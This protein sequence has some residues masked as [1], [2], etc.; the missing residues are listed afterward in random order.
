ME[1]VLDELV[2]H[3]N[4]IIKLLAPSMDDYLYVFDL[5]NGCYYISENAVKRFK[6]PSNAVENAFVNLRQ[7][8]DPEDWDMLIE[9]FDHIKSDRSYNFHNLQY[10]WLG[11]DDKP[12]WINCRGRVLRDDD[13]NAEVVIGCIN[14]IGLRQKA[15]NISGL[16]SE[17]SFEND[18]RKSGIQSADFALRLGIDCFKEINENG[19]VEYRDM[20]LAETAECIQKAILKDQRLYKLNADEFLVADFSGRSVDTAMEIYDRVRERINFFISN[21]QYE[22]FY[23]ISGGIISL[24][25]YD[26]YH[27][28]M[29]YSEFALNEAKNQGRNKCYV[30]E[31]K[32][33]EAF[34]KKRRLIRKMRKAIND[35]FKG[36]ETYFQ[37]IVDIDNGELSGA[38]TL[39]RF[40]SEE[41]GM[42]PP[43]Y[44]IPLLEESGL[45]IPVGRFVLD[46]AIEACR[47]IQKICPG[48]HISYNLSYVQVLKGNALSEIIDTIED[49]GLAPGSIVVELT[50]SGFLESDDNFIAFCS[51][52]RSNGVPIA[53]DDFGTGYS[54]FHYLYNLNPSTIKIDRTFTLKALKSDY[55]YNLLSY[56]A[57]MTHSIGCKFCIEGIETKDELERISHIQPDYIQG[58]YYGRPCPI[59]EFIEQYVNKATA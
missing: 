33:Y 45:I 21:N 42:V 22:V 38:E 59:D 20:I 34:S 56:M 39:L 12:I 35:D 31:E 47:C 11:R 24:S 2:M 50:E 30:F 43:S 37:P 5:K 10:R 19:G 1:Y 36:F 25:E 14:E 7:A 41:T 23:T 49:S 58:Y 9:D 17:S 54:N 4:K 46:K 27:D 3:F 44:F 28:I 29:K 13:G 16:M 52:L 6:L 26:E 53:L 51:S 8:V 48:F 55:E 57:D 18:I 15:D 32:D 40:N